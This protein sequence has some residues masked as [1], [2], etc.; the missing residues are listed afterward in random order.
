MRHGKTLLR[1]M[2]FL[3]GG[4]Q[5]FPRKAL[6]VGLDMERGIQSVKDNDKDFED[7]Q[8]NGLFIWGWR[9]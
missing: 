3:C 1:I 2:A 9:E 5:L 8:E 6:T 7:Y 4:I